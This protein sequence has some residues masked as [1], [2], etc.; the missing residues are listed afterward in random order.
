MKTKKQ[1]AAAAAAAAAAAETKAASTAGSASATS[2]TASTHK[3]LLRDAQQ[4]QLTPSVSS[5][6]GPAPKQQKQS[7]GNPKSPV[8]PTAKNVKHSPARSAGTPA[9]SRV[10]KST[11]S[12]GARSVPSADKKKIQKELKNLGITDRAINQ[13]DTAAVNPCNPSISEMVKTK[14]RATVSQQKSNR[15]CTAPP[16]V[17]NPKPS[18]P[19]AAA[20]TPTKKKP[21]P[22]T[23]DTTKQE[24]GAKNKTP[25]TAQPATSSAP[26]P[27]QSQPQPNV[28]K[29]DVKAP[30]V[31]KNTDSKSKAKK[32][33]E[34]KDDN[35][36]ATTGVVSVEQQPQKAGKKNAPAATKPRRN[37]KRRS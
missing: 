4:Q 37:P 16:A 12:T 30:P 2:I 18:E 32:Q 28:A 3:R 11:P 9:A 19:I 14:S 31:S 22:K 20:T 15:F 13:I 29:E 7:A 33:P 24:E 10:K 17:E 1:L 35:D 34:S 5:S 8:H 23:K 26:P 21:V 36:A 27:S 25:V 6:G